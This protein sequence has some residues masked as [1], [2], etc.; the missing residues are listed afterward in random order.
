M[1]MTQAKQVLVVDDD[2]VVQQLV[3]KMVERRGVKVLLAGSAEDVSRLF[4][5]DEMPN[6]SLFFLDLILP[7]IIHIPMPF[8]LRIF[9]QH[10]GTLLLKQFSIFELLHT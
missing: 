5:S 6:F 2:E 1:F 8:R 10:T 3:K 4:K 7:D 9:V